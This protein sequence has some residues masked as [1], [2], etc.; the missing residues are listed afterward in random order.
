[1][2]VG[3]VDLDA[4]D[5]T[6]Q[7]YNASKKSRPRTIPLGS[8][9]ITA[10]CKYKATDDYLS[11][12]DSLFGI[13]AQT[14]RGVIKRTVTRAGVENVYPHRFRHTFAI[15]YLRN[16]GDVYTLKYF[17]GHSTLEMVQGYLHIAHEDRKAAHKRASPADRWLRRNK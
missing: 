16:G 2:S 5:V 9:A 17:L 6:I 4:G 3:D 7:P 12:E 15:E 8:A 10:V 14:I 11:E 13:A 1:M